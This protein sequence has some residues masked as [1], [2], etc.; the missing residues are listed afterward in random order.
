MHLWCTY[1]RAQQEQGVGE[2]DGYRAKSVFGAVH[3]IPVDSYK[4]KP[5]KFTN[6]SNLFL[7]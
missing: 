5:M 7:E 2:I 4:K 1:Q 6:F 3:E